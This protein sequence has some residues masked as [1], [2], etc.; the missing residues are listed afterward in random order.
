[1]KQPELGQK[2][3]TVRKARGL[4][5]EEL[6]DICNLSVRTLQRIESGEVIPRSYTLKVLSEALEYEF[7]G[8][9]DPLI[10]LLKDR[11]RTIIVKVWNAI[12]DLFNLKTN[13]M[14]K[15]SI[16]FVITAAI[17]FG[18]FAMTTE[19]NAQRH[20]KVLEFIEETNQNYIVWFNRAEIDSL[21]LIHSENVNYNT[22]MGNV[23]HGYD[24][25]RTQLLSECNSG[26]QILEINVDQL[27]TE[28]KLAVEKGNWIIKFE[29]GEKLRGRYISEWHLIGDKWLIVNHFG[30]PGY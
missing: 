9:K 18:L 19:T 8:N 21:V 22:C 27:D 29:N 12:T 13:T 23:V 20:Q 5:Q 10:I 7:N 24:E 16:L 6:V 1:M 17:A 25:L 4:T 11:L 30:C 3:A 28:K 2:I 26:Y 15:V 14:K